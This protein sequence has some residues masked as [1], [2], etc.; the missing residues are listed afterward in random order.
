M[1]IILWNK[2]E[3]WCGK[4]PPMGGWRLGEVVWGNGHQYKIQWDDTDEVSGRIRRVSVRPPPPPLEIPGDLAAGDLVEVFDLCMW[5]LAEFVRVRSGAGDAAGDG[6]FTV[7]IVGSPNA[8]TVPRSRVRVRQVLTEDDLWVAT[9]KGE[10]I[11]GAREPTSRP[12]AAAKRR[13]AKFVPPA[14]KHRAG[15]QFVPPPGASQ[16]AKIKRSRHTADYDLVGEVRRVEANSKRIRAMEEEGEEL[17]VGY[18]NMEVEVINVNEPPAMFV[19]KQQKMNGEEGADEAGYRGGDSK[20]DDAKS[21]SSA[22]SGSSSSRSRSRDSEDSSDSDSDSGDRAAAARS[23]PGDVQGANQPPP[24]GP[25]HIKEERA[26]DVDDRTE[27]RASAMQRRQGFERPAAAAMQ[28]LA[29]ERPVAAAAA[30]SDQIHRLELD[31]Y[32]S[33]MRVFHATGA[34]TWEKEELLTQLRL[35]LHIS[36]DEHLQLI[37]VIN[38]KTRRPPKPEN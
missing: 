2:V 15:D 29:N 21:V 10:Q 3:A 11:P 33:L 30:V 9:Y 18:N 23:P 4:D 32:A 25:Q 1:R 22:G 5:K 34:L 17:F 19:D 27:S 26:D 31:A 35:Q 16:W 28:R 37:R 6:E 13:A 8:F 24:Q 20:N 12:T 7:K 38:G 14:A 36:G